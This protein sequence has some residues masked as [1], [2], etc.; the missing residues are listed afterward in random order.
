L[1]A[2]SPRPTALPHG[3]LRR[4][5]ELPKLGYVGL[6]ESGGRN[7][8]AS[9]KIERT[10]SLVFV[11]TRAG[12]LA[13]SALMVADD[14]RR[15]RRPRLQAALLTAVA[16]ESTWMAARLV[17]KG[18]YRD[19]TERWVDTL[20]AS[21][22]LAICEA[23][24]GDGAGAWAKNLMIGASMGSASAD[25]TA[26]GAVSMAA[27]A[28]VGI[29]A[30]LKARGR[31]ARARGVG[32]AL[33][34]ALSWMGTHAAARIYVNAHRRYAS[35]RDEAETI[36]VV[37][38]TETAAIE[39]RHRQQERLHRVAV[40]TL[41]RIA[42]SDDVE[43]AAGMARRESVR[44]RHA[45]R[46][47]GEAP[48]E[49]DD[50]MFEVTEKARSAGLRAELVVTEPGLAAPSETV[51]VLREAVEV[52]LLAAGEFGGVDRA[53]VRVGVFDDL[54][55]INVRDQG[56]GFTIGA[57]SDHEGR[58]DSVASLLQAIGGGAEIWSEPGRGTRVRLHAPR[59]LDSA[60]ERRGDKQAERLPEL[61]S[62]GGAARDDDRASGHGH[63]DGGRLGRLVGA[64]QR[65][66]GVGEPDDGEVGSGGDAFEPVAKQRANGLDVDRWHHPSLADQSRRVVGSSAPSDQADHS[67]SVAAPD[68]RVDADKVLLSAFLSWRVT[69]LATG[70]ASLAAGWKRHR[71]P[72]LACAQLAV[73]LGESYW[74]LRRLRRARAWSDP[75]AAL[76]DAVTAS[77]LVVVARATVTAEDRST[78]INWVPWSFAANS[79]AG[80]AIGVAGPVP[81][82]AG[83]CLIAL[84]N[85]SLSS[86]PSD[87]ASA[88]S[89]M[90]AFFFV[91]RLFAS[92]VRL[93]A[94]QVAVSQDLAVRAGARLSAERERL[95]QLRLLHDSAVQVLEAIGSGSLADL[96]AVR[97]Y[98]AEEAD[99][100]SAELDGRGRVG[101][102]LEASLANVVADFSR[103]LTVELV[104]AT[105]PEEPTPAVTE[106][107]TG[108]CR[109]ALANIVKH[110]GVSSAQVSV[111]PGSGGRGVVISIT[112]HGRGFDPAQ[113]PSGFGTTQSIGRR[114]EEV[115]G[116]S[117][118][119][120]VVGGGT[121]VTLEWPR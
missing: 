11:A 90:A 95:V 92:Q 72:Y 58:L 9:A 54:V 7:R 115:G 38:A 120:S 78:W 24:L 116:R 74:L 44:L 8:G 21:A 19:A 63:V 102:Q 106:A 36:A 110:A 2:R 77:G 94:T 68:E 42:G 114:V 91:G 84:A 85:A 93:S 48:T 17:R 79:V 119:Q 34:D 50:A 25:K 40:G 69:G 66:F 12:Q 100:L 81:A 76:A 27:L 86:G 45:L 82:S 67:L 73:A 88:S 32:L 89:A 117:S 1:R 109:E 28:G 16:A 51:S 20:T 56:R 99:R 97:T 64:V 61:G 31:D 101:S 108:A 13:F 39:E 41:R 30:G 52:A 29:A 4:G 10:M 65:N 35:L 98:A 59:L 6:G 83:A 26:S 47:S 111:G 14:R 55:T 62:G 57:G 60:G 5:A 46:T 103:K 104:L 15:Y 105:M 33:N 80:Q 112:D 71:R 43:A 75:A 22:S 118:L 113:A 18:A 70:V 37:R 23:G 87:A 49:F 96:G 107:L 3:Y 53:V 121:T